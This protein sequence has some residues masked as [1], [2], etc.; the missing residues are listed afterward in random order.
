M[1]RKPQED[2]NKPEEQQPYHLEQEGGKQDCVGGKKK[3][4]LNVNVSAVSFSAHM[5]RSF[6][7]LM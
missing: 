4:F 1:M 3:L 6:L 2:I 7:V 5:S